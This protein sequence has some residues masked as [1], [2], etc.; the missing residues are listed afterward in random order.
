MR[1]TR[2]PL[3]RDWQGQTAVLIASGPSLTKGQVASAKAAWWEGRVRVLGVNDSYKLA[4]WMEGLYAADPPWWQMHIRA[5]RDTYIPMLMSQDESAC[6]RWGLRHVPGPPQARLEQSDNGLSLDPSYINFGQNSGF[7]ALN[8]AYHLGATRIL[9]LGYD[10]KL[11]PGGKAHWFGSHPAGL[12]QNDNYERWIPPFKKAAKQL[13]K[14]GVEVIN[15]TP[16]S[17]IKCFP[18]S[19]IEGALWS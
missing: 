15:C 11:G 3:A 8:I 6:E 4:P 7:Q 13:E 5:V 17:A 19:T 12:C 1:I 9:L 14:A 10:M 18:A 2:G 16:G